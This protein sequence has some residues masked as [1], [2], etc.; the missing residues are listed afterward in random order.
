MLNAC[1]EKQNV[2]MAIK[3]NAVV[4][5]SWLLL[6]KQHAV[7]SQAAYQDARL[8]FVSC[9]RLPHSSCSQTASAPQDRP[10]SKALGRARQR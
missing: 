1:Y 2:T 5:L 3:A 9:N 10:V 7:R 8:Q 6:Y 4:D